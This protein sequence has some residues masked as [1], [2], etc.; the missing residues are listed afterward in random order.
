MNHS[1]IKRTISF[2]ALLC[3]APLYGNEQLIPGESFSVEKETISTRELAQRLKQAKRKNSTLADSS[4]A[5]VLQ[6]TPCQ[7]TPIPTPEEWPLITA[8]IQAQGSP[9]APFFPTTTT[10]NASTPP[11]QSIGLAKTVSNQSIAPRSFNTPFDTMGV[12]GPDQFVVA[13]KD[14]IRTF[15]RNLVHDNVI[16]TTTVA[17]FNT[18]A[19]FSILLD[20]SDPHLRYDAFSDRFFLTMINFDRLLAGIPPTG[21]SIAVSDSGKL[22]ENTKW[23]VINIFDAGLIKDSNGCPGDNP[24]LADYDTLGID[25]HALYIGMSMFPYASENGLSKPSA[26]VI[27]KES[28]LKDGPAVITAFRDFGIPPATSSGLPA[29]L[30]PSSLTITIQG[31][32]NFDNDPE[33]GYFITSSTFNNTVVINGQLNIWRVINPGSSKPLLSNTLSVT[34]PNTGV[35]LVGFLSVSGVNYLGN[36]YAPFM[37][38]ETLADRLLMA[39]IR[40]KQLYTTHIIPLDKNGIGQQLPPTGNADRFGARWY[41][42]DL[43]GDANG[44]GK[45]PEKANTAP[46]LVQAGTL[47]DSVTPQAPLGETQLDADS[48]YFPAIM[49]NKRGDLSLCGTVSGTNTPTSAFFTGRLASDPLGQLRIGTTLTPNVLGS[50]VY[51]QGGGRYTYNS[52]VRVQRWGDYSYTSLDPR[53]DMTMWTIQMIGQNGLQ[54]GVVA[55]LDAPVI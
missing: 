28:L 8:I 15:D 43:T 55:R 24:S 22:S 18:D 39:H 27:Q 34:V 11:P 26:Y 10:A 20:V 6:C 44:K 49:T 50:R 25:K 3:L 5:Q 19:D 52:G 53:D 33:F 13:D 31:V 38:L 17:F 7:P 29:P 16:D 42:I 1:I 45:C 4:S 30:S 35:D 36:T 47:W 37:L 23:T 12:I 41:Q 21:F 32:V 9:A 46:A 2:A 54:Q 48:Y 40:N 51:A 14:G